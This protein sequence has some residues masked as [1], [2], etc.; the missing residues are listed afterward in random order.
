MK[1]AT[2]I[3]AAI[4]V[5]VFGKSTFAQVEDSEVITL[6]ANLN[7]TLAL[8]ME[9]AGITFD[10]TTLDEYKNGLGDFQGDYA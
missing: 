9:R 3:L 7:V 10:F 2:I 8:S 6:T 4:F 1:K 5:T